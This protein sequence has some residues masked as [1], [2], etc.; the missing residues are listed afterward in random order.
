MNVSRAALL[1]GASGLAREVLAAGMPDVVGILDDNADLHGRLIGGVPVVG[2]IAL[3]PSRAEQLLV[4]IGPSASRRA[5]VC[6]LQG[7]GVEPTRFTTFVAPTARLGSSSAVGE[8]SI[9]LDGVV[10][11][12]DARVGRHVVVMPLCTI[13][14]DDRLDDFATLAAGASLGGGVHIQQAAYIGMNAAIRPGITVGTGATVGMSAAVL[15][16]VPDNETWAGVPARQLG[17][18]A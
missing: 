5:V 10:V 18:Y 4:C 9:L 7:E 15:T 16:D 13:T 17:V 2:S 8:G 12:A 6:R 14:H 11:T 3:A 1:V